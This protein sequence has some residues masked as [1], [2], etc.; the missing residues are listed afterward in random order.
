MLHLAENIKT[1]REL[2]NK[3]Q[4]EFAQ[5]F[6]VKSKKGEYSK[7]K[8]F[9]Y[10]SGKAAPPETLIEY[11]AEFARVSVED[12]KNKKLSRRD[13]DL[14]PDD[15]GFIKPEKSNNG[16]NNHNGNNGNNKDETIRHLEDK[17]K[18]LENHCSFLQK[19]YEKNIS[20][21]E[22][23]LKINQEYLRAVMAQIKGASIMAVHRSAGKDQKK[24]FEER[25][26]LDKYVSDSF[27]EP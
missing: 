17:L 10:E 9:T 24:F 8:I 12:L 7:D 2:S 3:T 13:I 19:T 21:L 22:A 18:M 25:R 5:L 6:E 15:L 23:N 1:I 11:I 20:A 4:L 16:H 14:G 26:I 27:G